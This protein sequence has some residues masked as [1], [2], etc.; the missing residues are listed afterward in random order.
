MS[1]KTP[2]QMGAMFGDQVK[3]GL[4]DI[5]YVEQGNVDHADIIAMGAPIATSYQSVGAYC[6][7]APN[8][9]RSAFGWTG[10]QDHQDFDLEGKILLSDTKAVDWGDL[11]CSESDFEHNRTLI[12]ST[13]ETVLDSRAVPIVIGGDDSTPIPVL[14][15]YEKHGPIVVV[16]FD[17]HIDWRDEVAG[18]RFG[19]SSN[20]RRASEMSWIKSIVQIGARGLGSAR[21]SDYEDAL[22]WGV[23]FFPMR[24]VQ[25]LS[26]DTILNAIPEGSRVFIN[27][28][29]DVMD[30][31]IVP[32]VIGPAP[33][34]LDYWKAV[35]FLMGIAKRSKIV[36]FN[37]AELM[38]ANDIGG[39]GALV[40]A[41]LLAILMGVVSRQ[42]SVEKGVS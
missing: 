19:L 6:A 1:D 15:A 7:D 4:F 38:P 23:Q 16:Q 20:M 36:G 26:L 12:R 3:R 10:M 39:R 40:A 29:I 41:R 13:V 28:D 35:N 21:P 27:F 34:G 33:G 37:L 14:N 11:P 5:P 31:A 25:E 8:M 17:A 22:E 24:E 42:I 9:I 18:E 30:P 32:A 2:P